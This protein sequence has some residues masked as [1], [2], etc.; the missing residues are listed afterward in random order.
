MRHWLA[1]PPRDVWVPGT[2]R[3]A[4]PLQTAERDREPVQV[5]RQAR[6]GEGAAGGGRRAAG[7][8]GGGRRTQLPEAGGGAALL[9]GGA[10]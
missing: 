3:I 5:R 7:R 6:A 4:L 10:M 8:R 2:P 1:A 9:G